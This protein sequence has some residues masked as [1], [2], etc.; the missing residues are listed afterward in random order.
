MF[1]KLLKSQ[2][3]RTLLKSSKAFFAKAPVTVSVTGAA[4]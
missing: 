2:L 4:G 1:G 3:S